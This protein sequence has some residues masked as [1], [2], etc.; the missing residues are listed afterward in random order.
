MISKT[1]HQIW[2]TDDDRPIPTMWKT[3][4][5]VLRKLHPHYEYRLWNKTSML[6]FIRTYYPEYIQLFQE[7]DYE[8]QKIDAFRYFILYHYGGVYLDLGIRVKKN[9]DVLLNK[10]L[11]M[12]RSLNVNTTFINGFIMCT[13][14]NSFMLQC[15][16]ALE[17]HKT[18]FKYFGK[19]IHVMNSTG[20]LFITNQ[21]NSY[22]GSYH[23]LSSKE[24]GGDCSACVSKCKGGTMFGLIHGKTWNS[25]DSHLFNIINCNKLIII[26]LWVILAKHIIGQ[27]VMNFL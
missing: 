2:M 16:N 18:R 25:W 14:N 17:K 19:H 7:Y 6:K 26:T 8:I 12:A 20:S 10:D 22:P 9:M 5:N 27:R 13:K 11:V 1:I 4:I 15:I 3:N 21:L 23:I 24:F